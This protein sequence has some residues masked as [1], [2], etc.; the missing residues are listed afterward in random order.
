M[1]R[2]AFARLATESACRP[3]AGLRFVWLAFES[4]FRGSAQGIADSASPRAR[5]RHSTAPS[6]HFR[7]AD[8]A[9][10]LRCAQTKA[11]ELVEKF[12]VDG[13]DMQVNIPHKI[14]VETIA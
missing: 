4:Q 10:S 8:A 5:F 12:V 7:D 3:L 2:C 14:R 6:F 1:G 9:S 13:S 11:E